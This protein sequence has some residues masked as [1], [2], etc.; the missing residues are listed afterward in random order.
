VNAEE[1]DETSSVKMG[2][3]KRQ[4]STSLER[5][6]VLAPVVSNLRITQTE[7]IANRQMLEEHL[8]LIEG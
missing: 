3:R 2:S 7:A 5:R 6:F 8:L 1:A 4:K